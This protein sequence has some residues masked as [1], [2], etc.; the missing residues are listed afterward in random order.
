MKIEKT[1]TIRAESDFCTV[2]RAADG[3]IHVSSIY[4]AEHEVA[5]FCEV[6]K[7]SVKQI[8]PATPKPCES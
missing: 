6:L 7:E 8:E 1:T 4:L 5:E 3:R 2:S